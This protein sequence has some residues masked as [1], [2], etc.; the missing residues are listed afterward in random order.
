MA[1]NKNKL[2]R[3]GPPPPLKP[4]LTDNV[5]WDVYEAV[6]G[7]DA[8]SFIT[9]YRCMNNRLGN[10][11]RQSGLLQQCN[12]MYIRENGTAGPFLLVDVRSRGDRCL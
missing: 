7:A 1:S 2:S 11:Q 4:K 6:A 5:T 3:Q 12:D 9:T 8:W 10:L